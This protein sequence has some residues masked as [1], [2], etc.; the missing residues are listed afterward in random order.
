MKPSTNQRKAQLARIHILADELGLA[1]EEYEAV[2]FA[3]ARV[4]SAADLDWTSRQHVIAHLVE[5][6]KR[7]GK[8]RGNPE[9]GWVD[10]AA[11]D[12]RAMLRKVI[13]CAAHGGYGKA[14]IDAMCARMF[15]IE[16][17]ELV[18]PDQLHKL[19]AA[20][21]IDQKRRARQGPR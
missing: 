11:G 4:R 6:A 17:L 9:W 3:V 18:A 10:R 19:V 12:R 14:Y 16:R 5:R 7:H 2:L 21:V 1:R 8:A 20:L 13:M 15:G